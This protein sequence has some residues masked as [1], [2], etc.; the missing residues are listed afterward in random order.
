MNSSIVQRSKWSKNQNLVCKF[1]RKELQCFWCFKKFLTIRGRKK[2]INVIHDRYNLRTNLLNYVNRV[3]TT[4]NYDT[5]IEKSLI[6][7]KQVFYCWQCNEKYQYNEDRVQHFIARHFTISP[8]AHNK[9]EIY[10]KSH[11]VP[12]LNQLSDLKVL[13]NE[14]RKSFKCWKCE[15]KLKSENGRLY[16]FIQKHNRTILSINVDPSNSLKRQIE[17]LEEQMATISKETSVS[18]TAMHSTTNEVPIRSFYEVKTKQNQTKIAELTYTRNGKSI[19]CSQ[20]NKKFQSTSIFKKHFNAKHFRTISAK[21]ATK[22]E[23]NSEGSTLSQEK[24]R[25]TEYIKNNAYN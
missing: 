24:L 5:S 2:Y 23:L 15:K 14:L 11:S 6:K 1:A 7:S 4:N 17:M 10:R 25:S 18:T 9:L 13:S 19:F 21:R 3:C 16:H 8:S 12:I 20:C 22:T